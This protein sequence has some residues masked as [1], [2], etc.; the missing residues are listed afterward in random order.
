MIAKSF[1]F[2][3]LSSGLFFGFNFFIAKVIG[4]Y[5]YGRIIY[6][7]SFLQITVILISFN[8]AA[9]YM[10][11]RI[12]DK[13]QQTF[14]LFFT[15]ETLWFA[16]LAL[17]LYWGIS[18][19]I[20]D[21]AIVGLIL[22][23]AYFNTIVNSASLEYNALNDI[24]TSIKLNAFYPRVITILLFLLF[25]YFGNKNVESYFTAM[26]I[27]YS[28]IFVYVLRYLK[29]TLYMK[30]K[31]FIRLW[32][33]YLLG[34]LGSVF[35]HI[36]RIMQKEYGSYEQVATLG[37]VLLTFAGFGLINSVLVKFVLPKM[38]QLFREKKIK[39][40]GKLYT[41]NTFLVFVSIVPMMIFLLFNIQDFASFFGNGYEMLPLFFYIVLIGYLTDIVTGIT[42]NI[43]RTT[44]YEHFEIFN[45]I[46]RMIVGVSAI[47]IFKSY[48]YG[49]ALALSISTLVYNALKYIEV[50]TLF[51]FV[52]F[53]KRYIKK[54]SFFI[55]YFTII[56]SAS[57]SID[58]VWVRYIIQ[59][60]GLGIGYYMIYQYIIQNKELI[61]GYKNVSDH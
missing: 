29:P 2:T 52:P 18:Y 46:M 41:N 60:C 56:F 1:L 9:L 42:G 39:E 34:I 30:Q 57:Q 23:I 38:H 35:V 50:Y 37:V 53:T 12:T 5:E 10:G 7:L 59:V 4:A 11:H 27:A 22:V 15:T 55:V 40:I 33:F 3:L 44:G 43:L 49:I 14:S 24:V 19:Y 61:S 54:L 48:P 58:S 36:A 13:D 6:D 17:P 20:E 25:I 8:Y 21:T 51:H 26:L 16:I 28:I 47:Y 45:E 32:K 31:I